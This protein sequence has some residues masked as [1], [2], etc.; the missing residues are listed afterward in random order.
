MSHDLPRTRH[1]FEHELVM[2]VVDRIQIFVESYFPQT[3]KA[4]SLERC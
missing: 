3:G 4:K 1:L 2:D